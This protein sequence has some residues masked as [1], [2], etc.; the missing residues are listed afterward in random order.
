M[1][2]QVESIGLL[3]NRVEREIESPQGCGKIFHLYFKS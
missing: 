2:E 1:I 3:D